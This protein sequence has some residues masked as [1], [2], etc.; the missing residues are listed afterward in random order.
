L[1]ANPKFNMNGVCIEDERTEIDPPTT[2]PELDY[3]ITG[4]D[5]NKLEKY[6]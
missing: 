1:Q 2:I 6:E 3:G 4:K 5:T